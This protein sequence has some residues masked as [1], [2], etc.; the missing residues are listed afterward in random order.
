MR[1]NAD[2]D[3]ID[4]KIDPVEKTDL[5]DASQI[6]GR[7]FLD[8]LSLR[9]NLYNETDIPIHITM[10]IRGS[11][12][13]RTVTLAPLQFDRTRASDPRTVASCIEC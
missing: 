4:I 12:D 7:I 9:L 1:A 5:F 13:T 8:S 3:R 6:N 11:N 10:N 2:L